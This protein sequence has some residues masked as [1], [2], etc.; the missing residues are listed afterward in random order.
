MLEDS[1]EALIAEYLERRMEGES[2]SP[3]E[4]AARHP[5]HA[6]V[7]VRRLAQLDRLDLLQARTDVEHVDLPAHFDGF[8]IVRELGRGGMGA[9]YEARQI[10]LNRRVAI[11][12]IVGGGALSTHARSRFEREITTLARISHPSIVKVFG[13]GM[14]AGAPYVAME[15]IDGEPLSR[16]L[17]DRGRRIT[18]ASIEPLVRIA[19]TLARALD[20]AHEQGVV[21]RDIKPANVLITG[22]GDPVL[23][24]FG[25]ARDVEHESMTIIGEFVGTLAYMAPEQARGERVDRR[26]DVYGLG[27]TLY[28]LLT[29]SPPYVAR[30]VTDL[31]RKIESGPPTSASRINP[32]L[33]RDLVTVLEH[34]VAQDRL[35][36]YASCA[37]LADDL[38]AVLAGRTIR[39]KRT[40]VFGRL[41]RWAR[42]RPASAL[43]LAVS[44]LLV[45]VVSVFVPSEL[46]RRAEQDGQQHRSCLDQAMVAHQGGRRIV[47]EAGLANVCERWPADLDAWTLRLVNALAR[48]GTGTISHGRF[49]QTQVDAA[50]AILIAAPQAL[51]DE[52]AGVLA[53]RIV[54]ALGRR[55]PVFDG[56][57][58]CGE[59]PRAATSGATVHLAWIRGR[60]LGQ[61]A[62]AIEL[63][64]PV[65]AAR[66]ADFSA[67][68]LQAMLLRDSRTVE[69]LRMAATAHARYPD[70]V[71]PLI[72]LALCE[73]NMAKSNGAFESSTL[74]DVWRLLDRAVEL[75]P[76]DSSV[77]SNY[78]YAL[79][80]AR[81][82]G[83]MS[84]APAL[85]REAVCLDA[86]NAVARFQ[87]HFAVSQAAIAD[88]T[89]RVDP[90]DMLDILERIEPE[91]GHT[92]EHWRNVAAYR[93]QLEGPGA[94]ID[95]LRRGLYE[96]DPE[97]AFRVLGMVL[98]YRAEL[99]GDANHSAALLEWDQLFECVPDDAEG[100][101]CLDFAVP[102]IGKDMQRVMRWIRN[103][104]ALRGRGVV[105]SKYVDDVLSRFAKIE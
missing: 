77:L 84:L 100:M 88:T 18:R 44:V 82:E 60:V 13:S 2:E 48:R 98:R 79:T 58:E 53:L 49:D 87:L 64:R 93:A 56:R 59:L 85:L 75:A 12:V 25:L 36:R 54:D 45:A 21:H 101:D 47:A 7:L 51:R 99:S 43:A 72:L 89:I 102:A 97:E 3:G 19:I 31:V 30:S 61:S 80:E 66:D 74:A 81:P 62:V 15:L 1:V 52:P 26:A 20:H 10:A 46:R 29:G 104:R 5:E 40:N 103:C 23:L 24:D 28:H 11:K 68:L 6:D 22:N 86:T 91:Y 32:T 35:H 27:A 16:R 37:D 39:A 34:A 67:I 69:G 71:A 38:E 94:A 63:L 8:E 96:V 4:F 92:F 76:T 83:W 57:W 42:R 78:G 55:E 105:L 70:E 41:G 65:V 33:P 50:R 95:A 73:L 9:V 17:P 14:V 90:R